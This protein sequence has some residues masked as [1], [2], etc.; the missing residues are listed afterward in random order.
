MPHYYA[1]SGTPIQLD[2]VA[3][4]IGVRCQAAAV[5]TLRSA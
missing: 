1:A 5:L 3:D 2:E 4:S